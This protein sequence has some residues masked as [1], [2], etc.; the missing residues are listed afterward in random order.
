MLLLSCLFAI[1]ALILAY[2]L[3]GDKGKHT[4]HARRAQTALANQSQSADT[5]VSAKP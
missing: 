1:V 4:V 3:K 5:S 2:S